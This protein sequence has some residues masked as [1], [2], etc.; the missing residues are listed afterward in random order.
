MTSKRKF[1][2]EFKISVLHELEAGKNVAQISREHNIH[3]I[4]VSKWKGQYRENPERAFSGNG[5][6]CTFE[7]QLAECQRLI[8]RLYAENIF[9]KKALSSLETRLSEFRK[10]R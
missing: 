7:A 8:G 9:L 4:M 1:T 6:I 2:R 5:K 3:P 10:E